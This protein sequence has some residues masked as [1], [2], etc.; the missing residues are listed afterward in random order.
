M[1]FII[2]E[3]RKLWCHRCKKEV[4]LQ[5]KRRC[6]LCACCGRELKPRMKQDFDEVSQ[7]EYDRWTRTG[8]RL[9]RKA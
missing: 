3:K 5:P 8:R 9:R 2:R 6:D 7:E 4:L 1:P